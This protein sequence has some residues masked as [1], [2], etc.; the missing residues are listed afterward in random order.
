[1][2]VLDVF[3]QMH[4]FVYEGL[5]FKSRVCVKNPYDEYFGSK[6]SRE[7]FTEVTPIIFRTLDHEYAVGAYLPDGL[8]LACPCGK[9]TDILCLWRVTEILPFCGNV[10]QPIFAHLV[11]AVVRQQSSKELLQLAL[12]DLLVGDSKLI[13]GNV[14]SKKV[15]EQLIALI[16]ESQSGPAPMNLNAITEE[17]IAGTIEWREEFSK[18]G[19]MH[20]DEWRRIVKGREELIKRYE[21]YVL[22]YFVYAK[23]ASNR[24]LLD[25]IAEELVLLVEDGLEEKCPPL[26][27]SALAIIFAY[28][29]EIRELSDKRLMDQS[30]DE[31][32]ALAKSLV[33][34]SVATWLTVRERPWWNQFVSKNAVVATIDRLEEI[35]QKYFLA[36]TKN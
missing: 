4:T 29:L 18:A 8:V 36:D 34:K 25:T 13:Y 28:L 1:M 11:N 33:I 21:E 26:T 14:M 10:S 2:T 35:C 6:L 15:P 27:V 9:F 3:R 23:K 12:Q 17:S 22:N 32:V 31:S 30:S 7:E 20:P 5:P 16:L 19:A 24:F